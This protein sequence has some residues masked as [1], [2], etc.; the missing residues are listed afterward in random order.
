MSDVIS[1]KEAKEQGLSRYCTGK[2][3]AEGHTTERYVSSYTCIACSKASSA[4]PETLEKQR[5]QKKEYRKRP[6]AIAQRKA[7]MQSS[8]ESRAA[9]FKEYNNDPEVKAQ[10]KACNEEYHLNLR[11]QLNQG[12]HELAQGLGAVEFLAAINEER[13]EAGKMPLENEY[14]FQH[15]VYHRLVTLGYSVEMEVTNG[16]DRYDLVVDSTIIIELKVG[17]HWTQEHIDEQL[18][19]YKE[20]NPEHL[21]IGC[22]PASSYGLVDCELLELILEEI[23]KMKRK[24]LNDE[25][26]RDE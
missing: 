9:Y 25:A 24:Q 20:N 3:C 21:V 26:M 18:Q 6:E 23:P 15:I 14:L 5:I 19:R 12:L 11:N 10:R 8:K 1:R 22:H 7:Y 17:T 4:S 16:Q 2:P 13:I